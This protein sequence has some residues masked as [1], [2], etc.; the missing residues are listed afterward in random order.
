M[1]PLYIYKLKNDE[2][3][4]LL[5]VILYNEVDSR[6][7]C[8]RTLPT[9]HASRCALLLHRVAHASRHLGLV[10]RAALHRTSH[11]LS[12]LALLTTEVRPPCQRQA[13]RQRAS[14]WGSK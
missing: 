11:L 7:S 14:I 6:A 8:L 2:D 13:S 3:T 9:P 4:N 5:S 10:S 1:D 12:G